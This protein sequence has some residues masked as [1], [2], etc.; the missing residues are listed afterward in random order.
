MTKTTKVSDDEFFKA[1]TGFIPVKVIVSM[2]DRAEQVPDMVA[3]EIKTKKDGTEMKFEY[4]YRIRIEDQEGNIVSEDSS[5]KARYAKDWSRKFYIRTDPEG[6]EFLGFTRHAVLLALCTISEK[7][8][9]ELPKDDRK[10]IGF[11]FEAILAGNDK[12]KFIDW[13]RTFQYYGINVPTEMTSRT[14]EPE[15]ITYKGR[16]GTIDPTKIKEP[17]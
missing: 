5:S 11:E 4:P 16:E 14:G 13:V 15:D 3:E 10:W 6:R 17:F 8:G 1:N 7:L 12:V 9:K 2:V